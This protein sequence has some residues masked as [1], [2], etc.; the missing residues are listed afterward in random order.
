MPEELIVQH[1]SPTLAGIKTGNL[2]TCGYAKKDEL[3]ADIRRLNK[4]LVPKGLQIIPL[5]AAG[6]RAL[7]YLYRPYM[8]K[9]DLTNSEAVELLAGYGY[10]VENH[11][12]CVAWLRKRLNECECFPH[13]IGLFLGYPPEDVIGFIENKAS[14]SKCVGYWKVYGNEEQAQRTFK[15]YKECTA[16]YCSQWMAGKS[17]EGLIVAG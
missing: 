3:Y 9:K 4:C 11:V 13:E 15:K 5:R 10:S 8:L 17:I 6:G 16:V 7:I 12:H 1:C 2:F 14:C